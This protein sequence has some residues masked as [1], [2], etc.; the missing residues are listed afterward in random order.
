MDYRNLGKAGVRVS[1]VCLGTM[2][3]G[4]PTSEADSISIMHKAIDQ[5]INFFDTANMYSTG[6]SETVVGKALVDRRDK[7]VLATKG[8]APMGDGP[9]DAGASRVH[10][11]R[12]LDRSLQRMQTDYVDIY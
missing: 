8:R 4:G 1:P 9:N 3:F 10:L 2:M 12:E 7:V 6:G 11:M 5:G